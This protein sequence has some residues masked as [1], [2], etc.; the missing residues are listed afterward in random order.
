MMVWA[1]DLPRVSLFDWSEGMLRYFF[2]LMGYSVVYLSVTG[3]AFM[4]GCF[5]IK[6]AAATIIAVAAFLVDF[7][8][9]L[10]SLKTT[11]CMRSGYTLCVG[12]IR[13]RPLQSWLVGGCAFPMSG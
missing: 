5:R 2:A 3:I 1:P 10:V 12:G 9:S 7:V 13:N 4:L 11:L 6:S 8:L